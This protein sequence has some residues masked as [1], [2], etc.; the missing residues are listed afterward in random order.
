MNR[1]IQSRSTALVA[2][3]TIAAASTWF[4]TRS[5]STPRETQ[6]GPIADASPAPPAGSI[7]PTGVTHLKRA[8]PFRLDEPYTHYHRSDQPKV[9]EGWIVIMGVAP[10]LVRPTNDYQPVLYAALP[11][12]TQTLERFNQ[13]HLDGVSIAF[14]PGDIDLPEGL[15]GTSIWFGAPE[16]PEF[17][18]TPMIEA[19]AE[20]ASALNVFK[21]SAA[22]LRTAE[23]VTSVLQL[24]DRT[25]LEETA[26]ELILQY[27]P[28][29]RDLAEGILID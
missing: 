28:S 24:P 23:P 6:V 13:G 11:G 26:A 16:L 22:S 18:T 4:A 5:E 7:L 21:V 9:T 17:L 14:L 20:R 2:V 27:A 12:G 29:E 10:D 3:L 25:T 19:E 15:A 8:I 1:P